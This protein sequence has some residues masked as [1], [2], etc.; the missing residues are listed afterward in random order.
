MIIDKDRG[1][2]NRGLKRPFINTGF[3]AERESPKIATSGLFTI[4]V[5][6]V[7]P[8]PPK[9]EMV[10]H[11]PL[12]SVGIN[13]LSRALALKRCHFDCNLSNSKLID[14]FNNWHY[15]TIWGFNSNT[16]IT[17]LFIN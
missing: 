5:K 2:I 10:K 7:P 16:D 9:L 3:M 12:I 8:M 15:Q 17:I 13:P 4:G 11:P 14:L 1:S 6:A